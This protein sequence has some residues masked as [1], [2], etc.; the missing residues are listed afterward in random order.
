MNTILQR[1]LRRLP[2]TTDEEC[3]IPELT[4]RTDGYVNI[5]NGMGGNS[6]IHRIVWEMH[7][8]EPIP[9]GM[10]VM[11]SC[12]N[13]ACCNPHH[14]SVGTQ[15][16]N[17][18][19]ASAKGRLPG[20]KGY[21]KQFDDEQAVALRNAGHTFQEIADELGVSQNAIRKAVKRSG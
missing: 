17:C 6:R 4:N 14:L 20:G 13:R 15:H 1:I 18:L 2:E 7:N 5:G 16:E 3:W 8:A 12:D 21:P 10:V 19:D 9:E 11:H